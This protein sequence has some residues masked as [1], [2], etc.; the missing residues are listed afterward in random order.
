MSW[1]GNLL[2]M[3]PFNGGNILLGKTG[4]GHRR[5]K[6]PLYLGFFYF[7]MR[8][9]ITGVYLREERLFERKEQKRMYRKE[10]ERAR[11]KIDVKEYK[12]KTSKKK[13]NMSDKTK[14]NRRTI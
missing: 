6:V 12:V 9:Q 3:R 5:N 4:S 2:S 1:N 13:K 11:E 14:C 10:K 7:L 8:T